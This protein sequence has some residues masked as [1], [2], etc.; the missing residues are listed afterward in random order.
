LDPVLRRRD[1]FGWNAVERDDA[2]AERRAQTND[3]SR[4]FAAFDRFPFPKAAETF[5]APS[6]LSL[7]FVESSSP[8]SPLL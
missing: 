5:N 4:Y 3:A 1:A 2:D 7:R 6:F 8:F